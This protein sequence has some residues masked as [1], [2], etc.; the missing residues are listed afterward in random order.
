MPSLIDE[1]LDMPNI[2]RMAK[3]KGADVSSPD[4]HI[5]LRI[6]FYDGETETYPITLSYD[7]IK[8]QITEAILACKPKAMHSESPE[9]LNK[10]WVDHEYLAYNQA[11]DQFEQA[12]K[13]LFK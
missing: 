10:G 9:M 13:E 12:I 6:V 11:L 8:R 2:L 7:L 4:K 3:E 1:I 5:Q